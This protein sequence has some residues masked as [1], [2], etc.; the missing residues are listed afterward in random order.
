ML[1]CREATYLTAK[2]EEGKLPFL[3]NMKL[4]MHTSMCSLCKRFKK[5]TSQIGK[6]GKHIHAED[7]LPVFAKERIE[8]MLDEHSS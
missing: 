6:E 5:Q 2:K 7:N 4:S 8:R 3:T 1:S